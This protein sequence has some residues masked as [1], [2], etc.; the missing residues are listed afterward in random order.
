MW[1]KTLSKPTS[2][3]V[4]WTLK[5]GLVALILWIAVEQTI[6]TRDIIWSRKK[7]SEMMQ[8]R[9]RVE[10]VKDMLWV[11]ILIDDS[12][13]DDDGMTW[14]KNRQTLCHHFWLL[15]VN[16]NCILYFEFRFMCFRSG[17]HKLP[18]SL[19]KDQRFHRSLHF[20]QI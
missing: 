15:L 14:M 6:N 8:P 12:K 11:L 16:I 7:P 2:T 4:A 18:I 3:F 17:H 13:G 20:K 19:Y 9:L 5:Y 1:K 10:N